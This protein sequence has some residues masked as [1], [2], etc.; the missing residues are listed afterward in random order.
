[1]DDPPAEP[2]LSV[3]LARDVLA[4]MRERNWVVSLAVPLLAAISVGIAAVVVIGAGTSG[5][6]VPSATDAGFPPARLA[7]ADFTGGTV[8]SPVAVSAL[9]A[10]GATQVAAGSAAGALA[11]WISADGGSTWSRAAVKLE[12]AAGTGQFAGVTHGAAGW[13]AVGDAGATGATKPVLV[14]SP[15][16]RTWTATGRG[17]AFA[18]GGAVTTAVTAGKTGYVVVGHASANGRT[19]AAAWYAQGFTGWQRGA[20]AQPGALD[21]QENRTMNAVAPTSQGFAAVGAVGG[22]PAAWLS[23]TGRTWTLVAVPLPGGAA[24]AALDYVAANGAEVAAVG[25][26]VTATGLHR[27]FA[28]VSADAGATWTLDQLPVP[29]SGGFG[30]AL[31]A[32]GAETAA[33]EASVTALTAA[34]G[35]FTAAGTYDT[36]GEADVLVWTLP[37]GAGT[38][39]AWT[40][41]APQGTG[42]AGP[43]MHAITALTA[44]GATLTGVGF[45]TSATATKPTIWQSPVRS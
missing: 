33:T 44:T 17:G 11:L 6:M 21:G 9:A 7:A 40:E 5:D 1:M 2:G 31:P 28:A 36:P 43:G 3:R 14:G 29:V 8:G 15:G 10:N 4:A 22:T 19:V 45:T 18:V 35:G 20:D 38:A 32:D 37:S 23:G 24:S 26:E 34:D 12:G 39:A 16:G 27:P 30:A 42:L 25:T 13:L 41:V